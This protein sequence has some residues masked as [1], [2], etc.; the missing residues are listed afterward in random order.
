[1]K[2]ELAK[3]PAGGM[4]INTDTQL[5][6]IIGRNRL[7]N[8]LLRAGLEVATPIRDRG[9]DLIAY[10]DIE[11]NSNTFIACPIQMKA[12]SKQSFS[13]S[14]KYEKVHGLIIA[15][16][17]YLNDADK[18]ATYALTYQEAVQVAEDMDWG[19]WKDHMNIS[20]TNPGKKLCLLLEPYR[21]TPEA[22][23]DKVTA[24]HTTISQAS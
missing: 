12:A 8:E 18:A 9:I 24:S 17:W 15:Y 10:V 5:V 3:P 22:W 2:T 19:Y 4:N 11:E 21:M 6:E 1:V 16:V 20:I 14:Q 7:T 23:W 13:I